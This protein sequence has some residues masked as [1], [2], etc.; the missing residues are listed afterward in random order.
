MPN[1]RDLEAMFTGAVR[2]V[3]KAGVFGANVMS[4]VDRTDL[5]TP[6]RHA[7]CSQVRDIEVTIYGWH[8]PLLTDAAA[9]VP[10]AVKG[11]KA[12]RTRPMGPERCSP[13]PGPVTRPQSRRRPP[14]PACARA[15]S[16]ALV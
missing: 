1:V 8:V 3:A 6:E 14:T 15:A 12:K 11:G 13:R 10:L 4:M 5:K 2:A 7:G 16:A 9:K